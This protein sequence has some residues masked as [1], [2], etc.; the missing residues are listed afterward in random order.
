MTIPEDRVPR[1]LQLPKSTQPSSNERQLFNLPQLCRRISPVLIVTISPHLPRT[2]FEQVPQQGNISL[3]ADSYHIRPET[4]TSK[5][6][7]LRS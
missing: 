4:I 6:G 1:D 2:F 7:N 3:K 5:L